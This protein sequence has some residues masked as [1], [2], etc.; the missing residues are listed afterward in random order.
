M[1]VFATIGSAV[2]NVLAVTA[3]EVDVEYDRRA[4]KTTNGTRIHLSGTTIRVDIPTPEVANIIQ[5]T[6][7]QSQ[8]PQG[9]EAQ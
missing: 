6:F 9:D 5:T 3:L 7:A 8:Q 2:I 4:G 1:R